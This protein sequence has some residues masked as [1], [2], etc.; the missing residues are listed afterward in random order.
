[1]LFFIKK[2]KKT[3]ANSKKVTTFAPVKRKDMVP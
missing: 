2:E 1:M 3:F